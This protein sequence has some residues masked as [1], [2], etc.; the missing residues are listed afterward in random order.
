MTVYLNTLGCARNLVDSEVMAAAIQRAGY[1]IVTE[2]D[3]AQM[4][5]VNTCS[6]IE[7]AINESID[8]ILALAAYK[9]TG[10]CDRLIVA[11]CLPERFGR[12]IAEALP[13]V[14]IFLGT[15]A[16]DRIAEAVAGAISPGTCIFPK[17]ESLPLATC[18]AD[19]KPATYPMAYLK[20]AEGCNR[21]CTYCIIPKLKGRL[22]SRT[23]ADIRSEAEALLE[24]GYKE[25]V[26]IAQDTSAYGK[27]QIPEQSLA[28]LL[29]GL[30]EKS[31]STWWRFL[32][33]SPDYTD[34]AL[35]RTVSNLPQVAPYFDL[36]VQHASD[37]VLRQMGR[38]YKEKDVLHLFDVIRR[39]IPG[40]ALRTTLLTGF[41]GETESDFKVLLGF[42]E[43]VRFDH[44]GVFVYSDA[45]D[46]ASHKLPGHV[47]AAVATERCDQLMARQAEISLETNR[48]RIGCTYPVL[49]EDRIDEHLYLARTQFQAPEVDGVTY[50][51]APDL[52]S[53]QFVNVRISEAYAYDLK[54]EPE[55][56]A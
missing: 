25:I 43:K 52:K 6:F 28:G 10:S 48:G 54:G 32:Y 8:T 35:I 50:V 39:Q 38:A 23:P 12:A 16:W 49:I 41:P 31:G 26:L 24:A 17:P 19:R 4:I 33:G 34:A 1:T 56:P 40:A 18:K 11:G 9:R 53:G 51:E 29:E 27:D 7:S 21:H 5:I 14:D 13:E 42:L 20:I 22:R 45:E 37:R 30:A 2:P 36:P 47:P 55:C 46:L 44:V 15:G 3:K